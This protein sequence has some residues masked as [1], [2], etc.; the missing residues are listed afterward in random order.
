MFRKKYLLLGVTAVAAAGLLAWAFSPKPVPVE[1]ATIVNGRYEQAIEE[2]GRTRL[3]DRYTVSAP[4]AA[5]VLRISLREGDRVA[6]GDT[7]A[8]LLP[9]MSAMVDARSNREATERHHAAKANVTRAAARVARA[10][11]GAEEAQLELHRVEKLAREGFLS[12]SRLDSARLALSG[13]RREVDAARAERDA[14]G[15]DEAQAAAALLPANGAQGGKPLNVKSPVPGVVLKVPQASE[16][17]VPAGTALLDVG[18]PARMEVIAEL[19]T[20]DAV[21]A[22]PG[23]RAVVER[24]GGP[25]V[26]G[27][28]RRV[29]PAA[30]TK[31]S[32]LGIE[33]QRVKVIVDLDSPPP[34][35]QAMGD[36]YRVTLRVITQSVDQALLAPVGALFPIGDGGTGVYVVQ[37]GKAKL[38][39][40]ELGGRNGNEAWVR[41]GLQAGQKVIVYPP[42]AVAEGKRVQARRP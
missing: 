2:D 36:G 15:H 17:T 35:W 8:V 33:E 27:R 28:V 7:V 22:Q 42:P 1:T 12:A 26:E 10:Q 9:A 6:A 32:A 38:Q 30:F 5:R 3:K 40:V 29:E 11:L 13:A 39:P 19:L 4:V 16:G 18:D 23:R 14:A 20:T 24:W 41:G 31:V 37:D 34:G 21:Q 25:P